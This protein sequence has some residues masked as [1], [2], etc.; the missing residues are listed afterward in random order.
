MEIKYL[1]ASALSMMQ[2]IY[3]INTKRIVQCIKFQTSKKKKKKKKEMF[4]KI[5]KAKGY[6]Q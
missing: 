2:I 4:K 3:T 6:T 5:I 1:M